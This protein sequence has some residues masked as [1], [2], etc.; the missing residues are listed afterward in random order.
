MFGLV[1]MHK[2]LARRF[3]HVSSFGKYPQDWYFQVYKISST[4]VY[5][6]V[7]IFSLWTPGHAIL[8]PSSNSTE[9]P[10]PLS[11]CVSQ[12]RAKRA[13]TVNMFHPASSSPRRLMAILNTIEAIRHELQL[14]SVGRSALDVLIHDAYLKVPLQPAQQPRS[15]DFHYDDALGNPFP[16][17]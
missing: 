8:D 5:A 7:Y 13:N 9:S 2:S 1:S 4:N 3:A 16:R 14:W 17:Q 12:N 11:D 10:R 6:C 15:L